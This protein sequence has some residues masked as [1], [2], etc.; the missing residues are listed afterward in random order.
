MLLLISV[1]AAEWSSALPSRPAQ[2]L[3]E[4]VLDRIH[5]KVETRG[6]AKV[7][8]EKWARL[9]VANEPV[10]HEL[11]FGQACDLEGKLVIRRTPFPVDLRV[12]DLGGVQRLQATVA[13]FIEPRLLENRVV[14]RLRAEQGRLFG[15]SKGKR[16]ILGFRADY[17]LET[18][19]NGQL[20]QNRGGHVRVERY[21]GKA[22]EAQVPLHF[23]RR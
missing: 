19:L 3:V 13:P 15:D 6:C 8:P 21:A 14:V 22:A 7:P 17:E 10:T 5:T 23:E 11:K 20:R 12:R 2:A 18:A 1:L 9:L 4:R 16:E